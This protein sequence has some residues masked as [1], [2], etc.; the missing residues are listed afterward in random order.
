MG[1]GAELEEI[2][3]VLLV[4]SVSWELDGETINTTERNMYTHDNF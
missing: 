3:R 2:G 1:V 4:R